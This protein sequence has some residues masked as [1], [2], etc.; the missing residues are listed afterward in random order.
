MLH[1]IAPKEIKRR[2]GGGKGKWKEVPLRVGGKFGLQGDM[3][4]NCFKGVGSG[5]LMGG[6]KR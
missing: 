6:K 5:A 3:K 1:G 4:K 2:I